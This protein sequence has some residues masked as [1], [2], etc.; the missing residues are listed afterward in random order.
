VRRELQWAQVRGGAAR[1]IATRD[2][3]STAPATPARSQ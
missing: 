3:S 2:G 1:P